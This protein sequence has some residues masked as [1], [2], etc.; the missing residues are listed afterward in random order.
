[1]IRTHQPET[2][3]EAVHDSPG[4]LLWLMTNKWQAQQRL[5]LKPFG[6][7]HVQFVLLA[8]LVYAPG[9]QSFTQIQLAERAQ[10]DPMMT[11]QVLRKLE[12]KDL[13]QRTSSTEDKRAVS[14]KATSKGIKLVHRA[15]VAVE[16]VDREFFGVLE[17][18]APNFVIMMRKLV[19]PPKNTLTNTKER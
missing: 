11:S 17:T 16:A 3:L 4:Y 15:I 13:V 14:L 10:T 9:K 7:T 19:F 1:M 18:D 12:A 8:C 6:L 5:T 2:E